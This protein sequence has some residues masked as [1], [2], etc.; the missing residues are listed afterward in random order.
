MEKIKSI[1]KIF[2]V[3]SKST[4]FSSDTI[5][6]SQMYTELMQRTMNLAK[7]VGADIFKPNYKAVNIPFAITLFLCISL[8]IIN[9][10]DVYLFRNDIVRCM[11]CMITLSASFQS[12]AKMYTFVVL[13]KNQVDLRDRAEKFF[14]NINNQKSSEI[15]EKWMMLAAHTGAFVAALYLICAGLIDFYPVIF[16]A[17]FR[18]RVLHFGIE[19]PV[20][21]WKE[22]WF[23]YGLN[24][25]FQGTGIV[26]FIFASIVSNFLVICYLTSAFGQ[27]DMLNILISNLNELAINNDRGRNN[28]EIKASIKSLIQMHMEL[29]E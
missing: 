22:S 14:T 1:K 26:M 10:Y 16:F 18:E 25:S 17:I 13:R 27:F 8:T 4:Y 23:A 19:I 28:R 5:S 15:F 11:F 6:P 2:K 29:I 20:L 7:L 21:N 24:F 9:I 12:F 3:P